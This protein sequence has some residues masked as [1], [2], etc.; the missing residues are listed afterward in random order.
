MA[1]RGSKK[2]ST[3]YEEAAKQL[4]DSNTRLEV[5]KRAKEEI[6]KRIGEN[7]DIDIEKE[8]EKLSEL[9]SRQYSKFYSV[10]FYSLTILFVFVVF[11]C[12]LLTKG[13][14]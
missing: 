3:L 14:D 2:I 10:L 9:E 13:V 11:P 7:T 4:N 1:G 12:P 8:S 5:L 6:N